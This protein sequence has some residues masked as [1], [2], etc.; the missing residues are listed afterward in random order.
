MIIRKACNLDRKVHNGYVYAR[1]DM[2]WYGLKESGKIANDDMVTLLLHR[3]GY[4]QAKHTIRLFTHKYRDIS[5][6]L[7]VH[8]FGMKYT[9]PRDVDH[10]LTALRTKYKMSVDMDAKQYVGIDLQWDY[11]SRELICLMDEYVKD[12]LSEF[13]HIAPKQHYSDPS[14]AD[15]P[16]YGAKIL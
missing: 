10:L 2:A 6:T 14:K 16:D 15:R 7:V 11:K 4:H 9:D 1:I 8:Y 5:F 13:Q 12:A 3:H